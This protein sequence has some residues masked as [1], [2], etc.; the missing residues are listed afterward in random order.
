MKFSVRGQCQGP[1]FTLIEVIGVVAVIAILASVFLPRVMGV[2]ARGRVNATSQSLGGLHS[3]VT[4]Y[5]VRS[6]ALPSRLGYDSTNAAVVAGRFDAD[7]VRSGLIDQLFTSALCQDVSISGGGGCVAPKGNVTTLLDRPHVRSTPGGNASL[8]PV[9]TL[10]T[11][12]NFDL[13]RDGTGDFTSAQTI[14]YAYLPQVGKSDAAQLDKVL[15]GDTPVGDTA[16]LA[17]RCVV[18]APDANNRVTI[19][20]YLGHL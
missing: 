10:A 11:T 8:E 5:L 4:E 18:S 6:N 2:L 9:S 3:Q 14:A 13:D 19:Y 17:G 7:L 16:E 15:D 12:V 20:V 1:G